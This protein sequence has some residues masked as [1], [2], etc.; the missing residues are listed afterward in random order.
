MRS[1]IG[2]AYNG[3]ADALAKGAARSLAPD[4]FV[5]TVFWTGVAEKVCDWIWL[6]AP[7]Y[8]ASCQLPALSESGV[9]NKATCEVAPSTTAE[10]RLFQPAP[11]ST[12][13]P[14]KISFRVVQYNCLSLRGAPAQALM[15]AGLKTCQIQVATFQETRLGQS[16]VGSND[17]FWVLSSPCLPT[18]AGG[19]QIWLH[20]QADVVTGPGGT[21]CWNRKSFTIVHASAQLLVATAAAGPF[22]F[23]FVSGHAPFATAPEVRRKEWWALLTSQLRRIP[24]GHILVLG[25]DANARFR[26]APGERQIA[27]S[28]PPVCCNALALGAVV[29]EFDLAS[30]APTSITGQTLRT[31]TSPSGK[32]GAID[33]LLVS[34]A[35]A[36]AVSTEDTPDLQD[37]HQGFDHWPLAVTLCASMAGDFAPKSPTFSR[38]ALDTEAGR[39][40]AAEA[41]ATLPCV[42]WDVDV[43]THVGL[44]HQHVQDTLARRLPHVPAPAR[45][46]AVTAATL[47]LVRRHRHIRH[48]LRCA[49]RL[50]RRSRLQALFQAWREGHASDATCRG[51][52]RAADR[53]LEVCALHAHASKEV[54]LAMQHDKANFSRAQIVAAR[55]AGPARF[56]HLLRAITRQGRKFKPPALL[57]V[58]RH[59]GVEHIGQ[60]AVTRA[61]GASYATAERAEPISPQDF[62]QSSSEVRMLQA[63]L[64][65]A[66]SPSVVDL[67]RGFLALQRGRAPGLSQIPAEVFAANSVA[68]AL[69]YAPV[70]LKLLA[71]GV[72]P[73][74]WSG[75]LAHSIP[76]GAKDPTSVQ[77][78]R[79]ILL[80]ESDAKAFRKAW[81]PHLLRALEPV[82]SVGQHGGI[83]GH[84]LDQP[85][86]L[87]RAHFQELSAKS[88][89]GGALF[90]D[91]AAAYYSVVRDFYMAGPYH[92]WNDEALQQRAELFFADAQSRA[93][94]LQDMRD[95]LWL[96]PALHRIV[97]AQFHRTW[98][99][100]G[101][102]GTTLYLTQTGTAPGSPVADALFA[103]LFSRF[104]HGM[105]DFLRTSFVSPHIH[106]QPGDAAETPA[107]ADDVVILFTTNSAAEVEDLTQ[108][109][110]SA[111]HCASSKA[112]PRRKP[113]LRQN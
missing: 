66:D 21:W 73:L 96:P 83:P 61:L 3:L 42:A 55:G 63:G 99:V 79:A 11:A 70:I 59:E 9:R 14:A 45:H 113:G 92:H 58:L 101:R 81:R 60:E 8:A 105:E 86:A 75:G 85:S 32:D 22:R 107:W 23:C 27:V 35:W 7:R 54:R 44:L 37:Q 95:G 25:L 49:S 24:R 94:F 2:C 28:S 89:S 1:H 108:G 4:P 38:R 29:E 6:L 50:E 36:G 30:N 18:G 80:L 103:F 98:Y 51:F 33:Y 46:P 31:W 110:W 76:K 53:L 56:A 47:V 78:W 10:A 19:C 52:R 48:I 34:S 20:K 84:T 41:V 67:L 87:V 57:P 82:R 91:C 72:G 93:A 88:Q 100:D 5:G 69:A 62:V 64:D 74:Q 26:H 111:G 112:W 97:M 12:R 102:P 104:L 15:V 13:Q 39:A 68:A 65:V 90:V 109:T 71:R 43:T 77:G 16:G 40:V 17:A 106:V